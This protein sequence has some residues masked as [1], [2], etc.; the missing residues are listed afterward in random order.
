MNNLKTNQKIWTEQVQTA[1][2]VEGSLRGFL[3]N[4]KDLTWDKAGK[5]PCDRLG[6]SFQGWCGKRVPQWSKSIRQP[7]NS[8]RRP[9]NKTNE[10]KGQM[11]KNSLHSGNLTCG[12]VREHPQI[13]EKFR[14]RNYIYTNL[15]VSKIFYVHPFLGK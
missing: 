5:R 15:V 7:P 3:I 12:L 2:H 6:L 14:F 4:P 11:E 10:N 9:T 1:C 8:A 13:P